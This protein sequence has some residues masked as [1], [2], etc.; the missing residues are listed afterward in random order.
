MFLWTASSLRWRHYNSLRNFRIW[1]TGSGT[2]QC[3]RAGCSV[4][5]LSY[6][7]CSYPDWHSIWC[8]HFLQV[9]QSLSKILTTCTDGWTG[10]GALS[11]VGSILLRL[12][13]SC[14]LFFW[15][16]Y[17]HILINH[18]C[19]QIILWTLWT[20]V[21]SYFERSDSFT[22]LHATAAGSCQ[23]IFWLYFDWVSDINVHIYKYGM[24]LIRG[25]LHILFWS[26]LLPKTVCFWR[27]THC[28]HI[29]FTSVLL[30]VT[31]CWLHKLCTCAVTY[32]WL[33]ELMCSCVMVWITKEC[34]FNLWQ[35]QT[36]CGAQTEICA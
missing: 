4:S 13:S 21:S 11:F 16:G 29:I 14:W 1:S 2:S 6:K 9:V 23:P 5:V 30:S 7:L 8:I 31:Y 3:R 33:Q 35:W 19:W 10:C 26:E 25:F 17:C 22:V 34:G 18:C 15:R 27:Q 24:V 36:S 28:Y 12:I 32:W 20:W